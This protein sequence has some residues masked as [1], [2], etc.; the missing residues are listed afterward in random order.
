MDV[1]MDVGIIGD[2][3]WRGRFNDVDIKKKVL[4]LD[5][6]YLIFW[7]LQE[8]FNQL[9]FFFEVSYFVLFKF[10]F[11]VIMV[12]FL[13]MKFEQLFCVKERLDRLVEELKYVFK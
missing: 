4:D 9:K 3:L 11:E 8:F 5:V 13:S 6:L 10:G 7:G 2:G 12:I 1:D